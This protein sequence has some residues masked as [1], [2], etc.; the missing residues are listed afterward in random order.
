M[1][2]ASILILLATIGAASAHALSLNPGALAARRAMLAQ[3]ACQ[4]TCCCPDCECGPACKCCDDCKC[5]PDSKCTPKCEGSKADCCGKDGQ[6]AKVVVAGKSERASAC[7]G[8]KAACG[9]EVAG[10][11]K[12]VSS[13]ASARGAAK[14]ACT[15]CGGN[16]QCTDCKCGQACKCGS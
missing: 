2:K 16:C 1:R 5:G 9:R 8:D 14:A 10:P 6:G 15:C 12:S 13:K 4:P 3:A 11:A 7:C